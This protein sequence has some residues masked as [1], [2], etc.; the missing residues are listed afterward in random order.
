MAALQRLLKQ[1]PVQNTPCQG[2]EDA[3][4]T[5]NEKWVEMEVMGE[6][7]EKRDG[8]MEVRDREVRGQRE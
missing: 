8:G 4:K 6:G 1:G 3:I 7:N 2:L 5:G